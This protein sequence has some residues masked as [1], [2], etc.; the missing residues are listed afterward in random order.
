M[1]EELRLS[2]IIC[3][4]YEEYWRSK[5]FFRVIKGS[6]GSGKSKTAALWHIFHMMRYKLS[7]TLVVRKT[8]ASLKDSTY[9]DL[10]WAI[11]RLGATKA[12]AHSLNPLQLTFKRDP[13]DERTW[14]TILFRGLDDPQKIASVAV[15]NGWL[16]WVWFEEASQITNFLDYEKVVMSIRGYIPP[17]MGLWKSVTITFNPWSDKHWLKSEYFDTPK[18]NVLTLT[19]TYKNNRWLGR[20]DIRRYEELY[21]TNPRLA[22]IICDGDWGVSEG[23]VYENWEVQDFDI[24]E[25][26]REYPKLRFTFGLDFG[27]S[28][29]YNAFAAVAIDM[30]S[31]TLWIFD[32][33]YER[34]MSNYELAKR[35][36]EKGYQNEVIVADCAEPKS[37]YELRQGF[38]ELVADKEGNM[39]PDENGQPQYNR[40]VLPNI[41]S[42]MKGNDSLQNGIQRL[43]SFRI[44]IH[45]RKCPGA[46][47]NFSNYTFAMDKDGN[48]LDKPIKE[49]DHMPDSIRYSMECI[50]CNSPGIVTEGGADKPIEMV[51][52]AKHKCRRVFSTYD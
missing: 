13:D 18:D 19:T 29:S 9:T 16:N 6:K 51:E 32:E 4:G 23:L 45:E 22:R 8:Y 48:F 52:P 37:I 3:T 47:D 31:R 10:L 11:D 7:N 20:E 21:K 5:A 43:Q 25:V 14:Q 49:H 41:R 24:L 28:I 34:G 36:T 50:F 17:E 15:R 1:A 12:W 40:Y 46:I 39:I 44:I 27:Y 35:I 2:Q 33:I 26:A 38:R 42:A 30:D